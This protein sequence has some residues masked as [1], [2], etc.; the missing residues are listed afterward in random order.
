MASIERAIDIDVPVETVFAELENWAG[1]PRWS[2]ITASHTGPPSCRGVGDEFDQQ[3]RVAGTT[4]NT[5][6]RVTAY[7]PP[8]VI[9]YE[10]TGPGDSR[11]R[12]RQQVVPTGT[13]SR[14]HLEVDYDLPA[15]ALGEALDRIYVERR[16][17]REA[18]HTLQNLKDLLEG[19]K[20]S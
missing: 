15:G 17:E 1:L 7:D 8:N 10:A 20:I 2:T 12:M 13:G 5:H 9:Q 16:N 4:L 6:W 11:M 19:T 3:L 14:M 18:D